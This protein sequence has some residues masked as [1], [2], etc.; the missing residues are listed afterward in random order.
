MGAKR[1]SWMFC[2]SI[3]SHIWWF[4]F[5]ARYNFQNSRRIALSRLW[6]GWLRPQSMWKRLWSTMNC[7]QSS[8]AITWNVPIYRT[9]GDFCNSLIGTGSWSL[10]C[11][12]TLSTSLSLF[13]WEHWLNS[14][15]PRLLLAASCPISLTTPCA[16][17]MAPLQLE[18]LEWPAKVGESDLGWLIMIYIYI[19]Q[20]RSKWCTYIK[21]QVSLRCAQNCIRGKSKI[22]ISRCDS[23]W[24]QDPQANQ[25]DERFSLKP[26]PR[27]LPAYTRQSFS[28][29]LYQHMYL[30][31]E[32]APFM[33]QR[34][35]RFEFK[36]SVHHIAHRYAI[37]HVRVHGVPSQ[38]HVLGSGFTWDGMVW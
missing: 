20:S 22:N 6:S 16:A 2:L 34:S 24:N 1:E 28:M 3:M 27:I 30:Q 26:K 31:T 18:A 10:Y 23:N 37:H 25:L 19:Y 33:L 9:P 13:F 17:L 4:G 38:T 21:T 12:D 8:K 29:P 5:A 11:L 35:L 36:W 14:K 7:I 32:G 15:R